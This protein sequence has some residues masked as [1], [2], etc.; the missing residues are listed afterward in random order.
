MKLVLKPMVQIKSYGVLESIHSDSW[1][2]ITTENRG[3]LLLQVFWHLTA[4]KLPFNQPACLLL[5]RGRGE[6]VMRLKVLQMLVNC[7]CVLD[8]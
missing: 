6:Q 1:S 8:L 4:D 2:Q 3:A 7:N 5:L